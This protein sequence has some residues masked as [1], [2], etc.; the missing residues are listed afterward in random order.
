[1]PFLLLKTASSL[2]TPATAAA[3]AYGPTVA[4]FH[5]LS[6]LRFI[7]VGFHQQLRL[8]TVSGTEHRQLKLRSNYFGAPATSAAIAAKPL[9]LC[10]K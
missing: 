1:M 6:L 10:S 2:A 5:Q 7:S 4:F 9:G 8:L 3:T